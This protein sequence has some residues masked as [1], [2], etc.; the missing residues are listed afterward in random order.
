[1]DNTGTSFIQH[2][3]HGFACSRQCFHQ[4]TLIFR[5]G[6]F[7]QI[8]RSFTI[9]VFTNTS[10][11]N[12]YLMGSSYRL[13]YFGR[14][15]FSIRSFSHISNPLLQTNMIS[16]KLLTDCLIKGIVFTGKTVSQMP[17][18]R[19]TPTSIQAT[20]RMSIRTCN[21]YLSTFLQRKNLIFIFQQNF[22]FLGR[23]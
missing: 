5:N 18:P 12:I 1:M 17:L 20:H 16:T 13:C 8:T 7:R 9:G 14:I 21:Q 19:I 22:R 2:Q 23:L 11:D 10:N 3:Y 6:H 15:F 4:I